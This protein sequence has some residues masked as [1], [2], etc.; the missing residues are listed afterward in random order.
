MD[1]T[2]F[3]LEG[4]LLVSRIIYTMAK[5]TG[6]RVGN[7]GDSTVQRD[8]NNGVNDWEYDWADDFSKRSNA[9]E[10]NTNINM[11]MREE[12]SNVQRRQNTASVSMTDVN[13]DNEDME[14]EGR[15]N[16]GED[17]RQ[18]VQPAKG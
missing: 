13:L 12:V 11:A 7:K 14:M 4:E 18:N 6:S 8:Q 1:S 17:A 9:E 15:T 10:G 5:C 16:L 3:G 2:I